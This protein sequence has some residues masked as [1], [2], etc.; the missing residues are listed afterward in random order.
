MAAWS[1]QRYF[2]I[3]KTEGMNNNEFLASGEEFVVNQVDAAPFVNFLANDEYGL[4]ISQ[5]GGG[6]SFDRAGTLLTKV[7]DNQ[8]RTDQP[9]RYIYLRD[10]D[11]GQIWNLTSLPTLEKLDNFQARHGAGFTVFESTA[12]QISLSAKV[13]VPPSDP[14]ELWEIK[15]T[16]LA[17]TKRRLSLFFALEWSDYFNDCRFASNALL[18]SSHQRPELCG[19]LGSDHAID[20]FETKPETFFGKGRGYH[21]PQ[22]ITGGKLSR[23]QGALTNGGVGVIEKKLSLG[24]SA[25]VELAIITGLVS[26]KQP[27]IRAKTLLKRYS[28][29]GERRQAEEKS[30]QIFQQLAARHLVRSPD[31]TLNQRYNFWATRQ[32][33]IAN[34]WPELASY[35]RMP[36][37][38]P[39]PIVELANHA[40]AALT[41][42]I[43][44]SQSYVEETLT[45]QFKDG[46]VLNWRQNPFNETLI[47][48]S[49]ATIALLLTAAAYVNEIGPTD[50][51]KKDFAYVDGGSGSVLE[52]LNR[53]IK[54]LIDQLDGHL[55]ERGQESILDTGQFLFAIKEIVPILEHHGD[56]HQARS[57]LELGQKMSLAIN[58]HWTGASYLRQVTPEKIG[59]P[60]AKFHQLDL[61]TQVWAILSGAADANHCSK[62]FSSVKKLS[63]KFGV[64]DFA[65]AYPVF[66]GQNIFSA[67]LPG[68]GANGAVNVRHNLL[69]AQAFAKAG[70]GEQLLSLLETSGFLIPDWIGLDGQPSERWSTSSAGLWSR[71]ILESLCGV[72]ATLNGLQINPCL[73]RDWRNLEVNRLFR[74]AEYHIRINNPLRVSSGIDRI[75]VDGS[76]LTGNVITPFRAGSHLVEVFLG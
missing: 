17:K 24:G 55:L 23:T 62:I 18:A 15:L 71:T 8:A 20:S 52:H 56:H 70:N 68:T 43:N 54:S 36:V 67:D 35:G 34:R 40:I 9:G 14:V 53:A 42:N 72:R 48:S 60:K 61:E 31:A 47:A 19:F 29:A 13:F 74:G 3:L 32:N 69:L 64:A 28:Q 7:S 16:N 45:H 10:H 22:A 37:I 25:V 4:L 21:N 66:D 63:T 6:Y 11:S 73:P 30:A 44:L 65:P 38:Q 50:W 49:Q 57:L 46:S 2:V 41:D 76:R 39:L 1:L 75:V 27:Q 51:L 12:H 59:S 33:H 58:R 5:N 26:S